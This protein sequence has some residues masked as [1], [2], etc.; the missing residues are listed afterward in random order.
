MAGE[1]EAIRYSWVDTYGSRIMTLH[2]LSRD[3]LANIPVR[4]RLF[5]PTMWKPSQL[6]D[7]IDNA[8]FMGHPITWADTDLPYLGIRL[9]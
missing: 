7:T 5:I 3:V 6:T 4:D 2:I 9:P 8:T 1:Q